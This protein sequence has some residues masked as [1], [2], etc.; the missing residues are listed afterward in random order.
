MIAAFRRALRKMTPL[1]LAVREL[2]EAELQKL[3][4]QTA[5]EYAAAIAQYNTTRISRL[6][7]FIATQTKDEAAS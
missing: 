1:E 4:A 3:S 2:T 6:R 7:A 5:Q